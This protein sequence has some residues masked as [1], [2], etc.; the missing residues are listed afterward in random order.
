MCV[1]FTYMYVHLIM[2]IIVLLVSE[3]ALDV[4]H[5]VDLLVALVVAV[6]EDVAL[7]VH[8]REGSRLP[9]RCS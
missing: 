7:A 2:Y 9:L 4:A 5:A 8:L 1:L 6:S 3:R